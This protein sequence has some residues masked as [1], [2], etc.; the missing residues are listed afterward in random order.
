M[1]A[2]L[3]IVSAIE[4]TEAGFEEC[5]STEV[6]FSFSNEIKANAMVQGSWYLKKLYM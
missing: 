2:Y 1:C 5:S 3:L 4:P 6:G